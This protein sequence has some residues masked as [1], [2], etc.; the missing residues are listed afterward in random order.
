MSDNQNESLHRR[1][2]EDKAA[3]FG[4][5]TTLAIS[6]G[7]IAEIIPM[8]TVP[9]NLPHRDQIEPYTELELA[10]RDIYIREGCYNCHSQ[11]IRPM[12]AETLRYGEW[13]RAAELQWD[14]PFQL[15]SRRIGPDIARVGT[16]G[17]PDAWHWSHMKDPRSTSQGSV[18]PGYPW[19]YEWKVDPADVFASVGAMKTLGV[20][21]TA[22]SVEDV[23]AALEKQAAVVVGHL[24]EQKIQAEPDLEIIAMIAYLQ[25]LGVDGAK[26]IKADPEAL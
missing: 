18:M 17:Y 7:C 16:K 15:G 6:V 25:N 13:T 24:A 9:E 21:Y 22:N 10:G 4:I 3:L 2:L 12:R 8:Y 14:H 23:K 20:P 19:L 1:L 11:M 26:A 5:I